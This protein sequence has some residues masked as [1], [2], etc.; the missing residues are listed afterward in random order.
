MGRK[1]AV[2]KRFC[3]DKVRFADLVNGVYFGG[4]CVIH[5]EDLTDMVKEGLLKMEDAPY[6]CDLSVEEFG[7]QI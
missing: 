1:D 5:S 2:T 6:R 3:S 4:R 7:E